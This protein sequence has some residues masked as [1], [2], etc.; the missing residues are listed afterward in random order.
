LP[1]VHVTAMVLYSGWM[2]AFIGTS[3]V[4]DGGR[5]DVPLQVRIATP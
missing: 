2:P 4:D 1:Q 3:S 5:I